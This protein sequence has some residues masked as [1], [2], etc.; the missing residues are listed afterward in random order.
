MD[1]LTMILT[2]T[3][4]PEWLHTAAVGAMRRDPIDAA[5]E[6]AFLATAIREWA[7]HK[8]EEAHHG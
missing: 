4:T 5:N 7:F 1:K 2:N 3:R 6:A 8:M